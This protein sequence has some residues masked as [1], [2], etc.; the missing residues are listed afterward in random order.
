MAMQ[1]F[2]LN[3]NGKD[4]QVVV[5]WSRWSYDG[6]VTVDGKVAVRWIKGKW[7][8]RKVE[9]KIGDENAEIVRTGW[10]IEK[11]NLVVEGKKIG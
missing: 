4:V 1:V 11:W 5:N 9:F 7:V 8:P 2:N 6:D 10:L 3:R